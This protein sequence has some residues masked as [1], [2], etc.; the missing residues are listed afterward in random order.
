MNKL[1]EQD[2][3]DM[4]SDY[5]FGDLN[6]YEKIKFENN[7]EFFPEIK[8]E[9]EEFKG[10]FD[11]VNKSKYEDNII[12][13]SKNIS[14]K[15]QNKLNKTQSKY[16][17]FFRYFAPVLSLFLLIILGKYYVSDEFIGNTLATLGIYTDSNI[18]T[19]RKINDNNVTYLN[20]VPKP[21]ITIN[22]IAILMQDYND[23]GDKSI[24]NI[25]Y[26]K[27]DLNNNY[28]NNHNTNSFINLI[29]DFSIINYHFDDYTF[30]KSNTLEAK[31]IN[32]E[33]LD[34]QSLN[35][36]I[37]FDYMITSLNEDELSYLL[38]NF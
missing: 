17:N 2:M 3:K 5:L 13:R 22:D 4:V 34:N 36:S 27:N 16:V 18:N 29:N 23:L 24:E 14:F 12:Q 25:N 20:S 6:N 37:A 19:N 35:N 31:I 15:V 32:D 28:I 38:N 11:Y 33:I 30:I 21:I 8:K 26:S 1:T 10:A 7:I 9:I